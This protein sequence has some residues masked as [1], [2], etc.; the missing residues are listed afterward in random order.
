MS[1]SFLVPAF[2]AGLLALAVPIIIH[3]QR[4][5][6]REPIPFPSLMFLEKTPEKTTQKRQIQRWPLL[7]LRCL[8]L[9]LLVLAFSRPFL[10][11]SD[12]APL[13]SA[14]G[15][16]EVVVLLD[17]SYSMG[18]GDRWER[19]VDAATGVIDGLSAGERGTII[20]FDSRAEAVTESTTDRNV[21]RSAV[22]SAEPGVRATRYA[23]ALRYAGRILSSSPLPRHELVVVSDF[24]RA[25]W[26]A[27]GGETSSLRLPQGTI[28]TP[29][30]VLDGEPALNLTI[31]SADFERTTIAGRER[32]SVV[33]RV[34][35]NGAVPDA[36]PVALE[37][38]GR[39]IET[40]SVDFGE[41]VSGQAAFNPL[42]LP[43]SG[44]TRGT[45]RIPND[46]LTIDNEFHFVLSSDQR[47]PVLI[48]EGQGTGRGASFFLE[49]A[50]S[51]GSSPGFR[52][53]IRSTGEIRAADLQG[54]PVV[55]L[56]Q[57][58]MPSGEQGQ[59]LRDYVE[60]GG[61][62]VLLLGSNNPGDWP[63][64]LPSVP[65]AVDRTQ[66][67]GETLG[68]VDLGHP[69]F[70]AFAGPR[71]GDFSSAR[72]YRYRPLPSGSFPRVLA[73]FG[74]GGAALAERPVGEGR[75]LVWTSTLDS[76]WNDMTLQPIFLPFLH[77]LTKYAAGYAPP[78][79]WLT[80]GEP[81]DVRGS[82]P[83]G[84]DFVIAVTPGGE[85]VRAAPGAPLD[86]AEVGFYELR[87]ARGG[88]RLATFAVNVDPSEAELTAFDPEEMRVALQAASQAGTQMAGEGIGLTLAERERQQNGWWYLII[89][90]FVLLAGET[91][92]SN[93]ASRSGGNGPAGRGGKRRRNERS[94]DPGLAA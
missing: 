10:A 80:V 4:R 62:L 64:V 14:T 70:E 66:A 82:I 89:A 25:G 15:D 91:L 88:D 47:I 22:R 20:L 13:I 2:F 94:N 56:N 18:T 43:E 41:G 21:L 86:L 16:R 83:P 84:E 40:R 65:S 59:R 46:A 7:L 79:S 36:V 11:Q 29:V 8:A 61:G 75:V 71:S 34:T 30:S 37:I 67:G 42:T 35:S 76:D 74:D 39:V 57:T 51:I 72:I 6:T 31:E 38:D 54:N 52:T 85:Q 33:A 55:I 58:S 32:V 19:A 68:Y 9:A 87:D 63:G 60:Q 48:L 93:R 44:S 90:A 50:L 17:R 24:Q 27:D 73:R 5:D 81:F 69:V 28:I 78:R 53:D 92:F 12:G 45:L 23:P 77:Q 49:R 1:L 3:L 26:D